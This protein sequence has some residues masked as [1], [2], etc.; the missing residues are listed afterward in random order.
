MPDTSELRELCERLVEELREQWP[1]YEGHRVRADAGDPG[2]IYVALREARG[3]QA[4]GEAFAEQ[5]DPWLLERLDEQPGA[6][7]FAV[8]IGRSDRDL[9]LQ[10]DVRPRE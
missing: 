7:A 6:Y 10:V 5:L 2:K 4:V 3:E 1:K 8:S 9:L